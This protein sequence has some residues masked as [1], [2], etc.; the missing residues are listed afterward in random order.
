[1]TGLD[2]NTSC[3]H[4]KMSCKHDNS[5][6]Q[7]VFEPCSI[8]V[9]GASANPTK[10][11]HQILLALDESGYAG[12]VYAVNRGGG[13]ILGRPVYTSVEELPETAESGVQA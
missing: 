2:D 1:M 13:S 4:D 3:Q 9:V 7:R 8:A 12:A 5:Q 6:L 10:R 11:G